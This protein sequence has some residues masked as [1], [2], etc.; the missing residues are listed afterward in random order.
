MEEY[1][2]IIINKIYNNQAKEIKSWIIG[3]FLGSHHW[4]R[5][6]YIQ[7]FLYPTIFLL[8]LIFSFL[9]GYE[10]INNILSLRES[11]LDIIAFSSN[12]NYIE[13]NVLDK[14]IPMNYF[15]GLLISISVVLIWWMVDLYL[16]EKRYNKQIENIIN[17]K[18]NK[19]IFVAYLLWMLV[20]AFGVHRFYAGKFN[21][22][23]IFLFCTL[24]SWTMITGI[25][26]FIWYLIDV[27]YLQEYIT[28]KNKNIIFNKQ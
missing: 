24:T 9:F 15:Y 17:I 8:F 3:G 28:E 16:I 14:V 12:P 21:T 11:N 2:K 7:M 25:V 26:V 27:F 5:K 13:E 19:S 10:V 4:E 22:G 20:G 1:K 6:N 23:L 18:K